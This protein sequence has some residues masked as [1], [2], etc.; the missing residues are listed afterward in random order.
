M[1]KKSVNS[2]SIDQ[3]PMSIP[4]Q[5]KVQSIMNSFEGKTE[6]N[7]RGNCQLDAKCGQ[8]YWMTLFSWNNNKMQ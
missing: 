8:R 7:F 5:G 4:F 2:A 1:Q 3:L 6:G